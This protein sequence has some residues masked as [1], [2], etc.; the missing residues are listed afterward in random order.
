MNDCLDM[1]Y[2][3]LNQCSYIVLDEADRMVDMGFAPQIEGI[4]DAMGGLMKSEI[5]TEAYQQEE[6]DVLALQQKSVPKHRVTAMFSA[7]MPM[8]VERIASKYLR[9]PAKISIGDR[10]SSKNARIIQR[11]VFLNSP[12]QKENKLRELLQDRRFSPDQKV[13]VFVNEKKHADGV[14]R[15]V[16]RAGRACVVLHGGK[17]QDEREKNLAS[18]R[19]GGVVLVGKFFSSRSKIHS[20]V[21]D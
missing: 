13:I 20:S 15:M 7:T 3:V 17:S 4:L 19:K 8:E 2:L 11:I 10:D 5:E 12:S 18:F 16:E 1:A 21:I 6:Q 14:G 9:H